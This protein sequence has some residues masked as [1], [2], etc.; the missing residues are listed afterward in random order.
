MH[1]QDAWNEE[2]KD[3]MSVVRL[4]IYCCVRH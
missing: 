2:P 1:L 4:H 3:A